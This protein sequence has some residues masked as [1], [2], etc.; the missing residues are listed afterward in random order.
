MSPHNILISLP[1]WL[2]RRWDMSG[3]DIPKVVVKEDGTSTKT[4]HE[5]RKK[6]IYFYDAK[7][8]MV[9]KKTNYGNGLI[10]TMSISYIGNHQIKTIVYE[11]IKKKGDE[12]E[13]VS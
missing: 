2:E 4:V 9:K 5:G 3:K 10:R 12:E 13:D 1:H 11:S 7:G 8:K 6:I